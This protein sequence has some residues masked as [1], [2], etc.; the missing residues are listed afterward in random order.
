[1]YTFLLPLLLLARKQYYLPQN[2]LDINMCFA[3]LSRT[4]VEIFFVFMNTERFTFQ[5]GIDMLTHKSSVHYFCPI[6]A[7][8][9][10]YSAVVHN[11]SRITFKL[12][13]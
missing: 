10:N 13:S 7:T 8:Y 2:I 3:L 6:S 4:L 1:M 5:A 9:L 11:F 12:K